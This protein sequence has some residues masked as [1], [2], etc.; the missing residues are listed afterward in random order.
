[1][2]EAY[3]FSMDFYHR[4]FAHLIRTAPLLHLA[5]YP[6]ENARVRAFRETTTL[7]LME[8]GEACAMPLQPE[9]EGFERVQLRES[10]L[11]DAK[12]TCEAMAEG[13]DFFGIEV[14]SI[15]YEDGLWRFDGF[16][17]RNVVLATGAYR[18]VLEIPYIVLRPVWGHR[19][20]IR[21]STPLPCH[22]HQYVSVA[23]TDG[24]G[25]GAIGAT[26]DVHYHPQTADRPY[27]IEAGRRELLEK[28][29]RSLRLDDV[30]ILR[31]YTG[32][33]SGSND[34]LPIVGAVADA[35]ASVREN[36]GL[37]RG[38]VPSAS[39]LRFVPG[40]YIVNGSGGYGFVLGPYL[41]AALAAHI[42]QGREVPHGLSPV[43]FLLRRA[44]RG[45]TFS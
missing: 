6:D 11:V 8:A 4:N 23:A 9:T 45:E 21:T 20:D 37:L 15:Q 25:Y 36:P 28:A 26:H 31:D 2:E 19:V 35:A 32:L 14:D 27:D 18:P 38:E 16:S 29:R 43:R 10:G 41:G 12:R 39:G 40:M 13:A 22:L 5:K 42:T 34:Y 30:E 33:R 17:A 44:K 3:L 24:E 1:M 7:P